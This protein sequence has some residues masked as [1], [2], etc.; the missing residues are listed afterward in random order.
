M[1]AQSDF[2]RVLGELLIEAVNE[3]YEYGYLGEPIGG[4]AFK[5]RSTTKHGRHR[6]RLMKNDQVYAIVDAINFTVPLNPEIKIKLR[7]NE[8]GEYQVEGPDAQ[9]V[10]DSLVG[11]PGVGV[12]PHSHRLGFGLEDFVEQQR[13]EPGLVVYDSPSLNVRVYP[14]FHLHEGAQQYIPV[15]TVSV[16]SAV[17]LAAGTFAWA[18]VGY[19]PAELDFVVVEGP[20]AALKTDLTL[21]TLAAIALPD[22]VLPLGGVKLKA[23]QTEITDGA[24]FGDCRGF[25]GAG[26]GGGGAATG[27][28]VL[29]CGQPIFYEGSQLFYGE[30]L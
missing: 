5:F 1:T 20:G 3:T 10:A 8:T 18:K 25:F 27:D 23:A 15:S 22:G 13:F 21:A 16:S 6:V 30:T 12:G 26:S 28:P 7:I 2:K 14:F 24:D 9:W 17:P 11:L 29:Y 4:G 19:D